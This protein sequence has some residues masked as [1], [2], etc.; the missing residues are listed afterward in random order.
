MENCLHLCGHLR[1]T[2]VRITPCELF[3]S[4]FDPGCGQCL[5]YK[6]REG[7]NICKRHLRILEG[8]LEFEEKLYKPLCVLPLVWKLFF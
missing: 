8:Y 1:E 2:R 7:G 6:V 3:V 4:F 5:K